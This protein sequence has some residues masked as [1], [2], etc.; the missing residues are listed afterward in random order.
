MSV[1]TADAQTRVYMYDL[2]NEA[3]EHGFKADDIWQLN[4]VTEAEKIKLQ[5][6]YYPAIATKVYPEILVQVFQQIK[7]KLKQSLNLQEQEMNTRS[8]L[9]E[10]LTYIVA[11]NPK[12][13]RA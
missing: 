8:V 2:M 4:A 9:K 10:D 6:D 1:T 11:F 5:R 3:K 7:A 12:R 13:P